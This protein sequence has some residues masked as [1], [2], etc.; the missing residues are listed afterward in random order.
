M[1]NNKLVQD[2]EI[3]LF[4]L[5]GW[6][7]SGWLY[8]VGSAMFGVIFA[9]V[10]ITVLPPKYEAVAVGQ[11]GQAGMVVGSPI[12]PVTQTVERMKSPGFQLKVAKAAGVQEWVDD[13]QRSTGA[14]TK[15]FTL[16]IIKSTENPGPGG[17]G[18][19]RIESKCFE[20]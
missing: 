15:Y 10:V 3:S 2:D 14:A 17:R 5:W 13:L 8:V 6:L 9:G 11:V 18:G 1:S 20:S 19:D 7:R 4:D 12:E 16:Q